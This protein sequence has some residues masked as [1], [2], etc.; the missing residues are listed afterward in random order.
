MMRRLRWTARAAISLTLMMLAHYSAMATCPASHR[1][2]STGDNF[3]YVLTPGLCDDYYCTGPT[4]TSI[5]DSF[6]GSFWALGHGN[7]EVGVGIDNGAFP[8]KE[9]MEFPYPGYPA[10]LFTDWNAD[11][12]IDGCADSTFTGFCMAVLLS[13]END[14]N[15]GFYSLATSNFG[16]HGYDFS[17]SGS[18]P[19]KLASIPEPVIFTQSLVDGTTLEVGAGINRSPEGNLLKAPCIDDPELGFKIYLQR[20][21]AGAPAPTS[22]RIENWTPVGEITTRPNTVPVSIDCSEPGDVFLATSIAFEDG[23]ETA[24]VSANSLRIQCDFDGCLGVDGD[25]DGVC[26][27]DCNDLLD[28]VYPG[29]PQICDFRNNDCDHPNWPSVQ[30]TNEFDD[31][32]D[33]YAEC[34]GDCDD[35]RSDI[36]PD[37]LEICD[38]VN[39]NCSSL[40]WPLLVN[41]LEAD[42][43]GDGLSECQGDCD[44]D[45][46][47]SYP[48]AA[49]TCDG[50][51]NDCDGVSDIACDA[52]CP[53]P[54]RVG[55]ES[56]VVSERRGVR[57]PS[58]AWN[59]NG[60]GMAWVD[61]RVSDPM[62]YFRRLSAD[63]SAIGGDTALSGLVFSNSEVPILIWTGSEYGIAWFGTNSTV[64]LARVDAQGM[65]IGAEFEVARNVESARDFSIIWTGARY[66]MAWIDSSDV[67]RFLRFDVPEGPRE[68]SIVL[69]RSNDITPTRPAIAWNGSGYGV[70]WLGDPRAPGFPVDTYFVRLNATGLPLGDRVRLTE[71]STADHDPSIV[72]SGNEYGVAWSDT[73]AL[74]SNIF[75]TRLDLDGGRIGNDVNLTASS[76]SSY[77]PRVVWTGTEYAV[78]WLTSESSQLYLYFSHLSRDGLSSNERFR[79]SDTFDS[80]ASPTTLQWNGSTFGIAWTHPGTSQ[81]SI[82]FATIGCRC[83]DADS[84]GTS[85]CNDC[86]DTNLNVYPGA[87]QICDDLNNDCDHPDF[88]AL[89]DN[90]IDLDG[91]SFSECGGDCDDRTPLVYP[92]APQLCDGVNNDCSQPSWPEVDADEIDFDGDLLRACEGDCDDR[93][94]LVYPNAYQ[95]CDGVNN[96]CLDPN[97]PVVPFDEL[98]FDNDLYLVCDLDC[99]DD[100]AQTNPGAPERC[101]GVD[102][103]CNDEIDEGQDFDNDGVTSVCDNC[104]EIFNPDQLNEDADAFGDACDNCL[105]TPN[106]TQSDTDFDWS[107]DECDNCQ[108]LFNP[109][110][111]DMDFDSVGDACDNCPVVAN[112]SQ[113]D[114]D[115]DSEGDYCDLDDGLIHVRLGPQASLQWQHEAGFQTWNLY[116]GDLALLRATGE[117]TQ[118]PGSNPVAARSCALGQLAIDVTVAVVRNQVAF[119]LVSGSDAGAEGNLGFNSDNAIRVNSNPCP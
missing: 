86:D 92:G 34:D 19:I 9:W 64:Y 88:P 20:V 40:G 101:N 67:M 107:G 66:A 15:V 87:P 85:T 74:S 16:E 1:I 75:F 18:R 108:T 89:P 117:Y 103:N 12:R 63:G 111:G 23:F 105:T 41:T 28:T 102:D 73:V 36:H 72:F 52:D 106:P 58:L 93:H 55:E 95:L 54:D 115:Q 5:S 62:L 31:D 91:D 100:D 25:L 37:A 70:V 7:P 57:G 78:S 109:D 42:D 47:T 97:W 68:P 114:F 4:S 104:L 99:D 112:A 116:Q 38:G 60:Y 94:A 6:E 76:N 113:S 80:V 45:R 79:V 44:D 26:A 98:D 8:A 96:D 84:D 65:E 24:H 48:G 22:R 81:Q 53:S 39:N 17:Q 118:A 51:D 21:A 13:D 46:A 49:E 71:T 10:V 83:F 14:E 2:S 119:F 82:V 29:A 90:E 3:S 30:G 56:V 27:G 32:G 69:T 11:S 33:S 43:D 35:S 77:F 61:E 59:G 50:L 110:Q